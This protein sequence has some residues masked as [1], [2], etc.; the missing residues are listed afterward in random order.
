MKDYYQILGLNSDATPAEIKKAF[1]KLSVIWHPDKHINDS[2]EKRKEAE[3]KFK[4][5]NEAYSVLSDAQKKIEYDNRSKYRTN[6]YTTNAAHDYWTNF[7]NMN[8]YSSVKQY[9]KNIIVNV[10][11]DIKEIYR[12]EI[13]TINYKKSVRCKECHGSGGKTEVCHKCDGKGFIS[14]VHERK[15]L[16]AV[17]VERIVCPECKGKGK[18]VVEACHTCGG[19]GFETIDCSYDIDLTYLAADDKHVEYI[20]D[21]QGGDES[22]TVGA[23]NGSLIFSINI[24]QGDYKVV[25]NDLISVMEVP[26]YDLIL[27]CKRIITLPDD[28][29]L[30]ITIPENSYDGQKIRIKG[31]GLMYN[32]SI[33]DYFI[34]LKAE[35]P[36]ITPEVKKLLKK[37]STIYN[38]KE[39]A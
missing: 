32:N 34:I 21:E 1:K 35:Y 26:Y 25:E 27:G 16:N 9:G 20:I 5:I 29:Q 38:K 7:Y 36:K 4:E 10:D 30:S 37:I 24:N 8:N 31:K 19:T 14:K 39:A 15:D 33:G 22:A 12:R 18:K 3:D 2:E 13:K 28:K 11:I 23:P 17:F 6:Y